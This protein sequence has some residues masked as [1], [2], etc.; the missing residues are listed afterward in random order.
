MDFFASEKRKVQLYDVKMLHSS[1]EEKRVK[2]IMSM[3]LLGIPLTEMP[4]EVRAAFAT[5]SKLENGIAQCNVEMRPKPQTV[6]AWATDKSRQREWFSTGCEV[7]SLI[8]TR[9]KIEGNKPPEE[10]TLE[11]D[12]MISGD[13]KIWDWA[14]DYAGKF[15]WASF[16]QTQEELKDKGQ[17]PASKAGKEAAAG[18]D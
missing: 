7:H 6:E 4:A 14:W 15:F 9:P 3:P 18:K 12:M 17:Q 2:L 11:F 10:V 16:E 13:R 1:L 5:V 8:V